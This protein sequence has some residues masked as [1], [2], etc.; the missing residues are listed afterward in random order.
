MAS[1][2]Y[3]GYLPAKTGGEMVNLQHVAALHAAG[4]RCVLLVNEVF[5]PDDVPADLKLPIEPLRLARQFAS[6]DVVV[7]PEYYRDALLHFTRQPCRTVLHVQ[8]PFLL[9]R[10]VQSIA[11]INALPWLGALSC[12]QFCSETLQAMGVRAKAAVVRPPV[13]PVFYQ[14]AQH[15]LAKKLQIAY[16]PDKRPK[17]APV[18]RAMFQAR[19]PQWASV[20]WVPIVNTSRPECARLMAE[21]AVFASF[22]YLEGLGLPPLEAMASGCLVCGFTGHGGTEYATQNNGRWVTEGDYMGF[23]DA[24]AQ[25]VAESSGAALAPVA[26]I[27]GGSLVKSLTEGDERRAAGRLTAA[28]FSQARFEAEL[29][30]AWRNMLGTRLASYLH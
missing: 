17:E 19:Y 27:D 1:I 26:G 11:E 3:I 20:P 7:V 14:S 25:A 15:D 29:L 5:S 21:S 24:L 13:L 28:R 9:F 22:S 18:V 10:G 8:G 4:L 12:S 23:A 6:D 16:M 30:T 2:Y